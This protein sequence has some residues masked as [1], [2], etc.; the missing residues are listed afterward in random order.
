[1]SMAVGHR[2]DEMSTQD[3]LACVGAIPKA[4]DARNK[5]IAQIKLEQERTGH[6]VLATL[7]HDLDEKELKDEST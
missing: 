7:Y 1:M 2:V 3:V 6:E 5:V 4:K